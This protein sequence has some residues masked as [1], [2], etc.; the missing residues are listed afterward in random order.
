MARYFSGAFLFFAAA[1]SSLADGAVESDAISLPED[2]RVALERNAQAVSTA[3]TIESVSERTY[4]QTPGTPAPTRIAQEEVQKYFN[5]GRVYHRGLTSLKRRDGTISTR[6][7]EISYDGHVFYVGTPLEGRHSTLMKLLGENPDGRGVHDPLLKDTYL[8]AAGFY[9]PPTPHAWLS[10]TLNSL[11]IQSVN[12]G[13][14]LTCDVSENS[15]VLQVEVPDRVVLRAGQ[16]DIE[17][18]KKEWTA[19]GTDP[20]FIERELSIL[21]ELKEMI[22][23]RVLRFVLDPTK[24][25]AVV[26]RSETTADGKVILRVSCSDFQSAGEATLQLPKECRIEYFTIPGTLSDHSES[27]HLTVKA[28]LKNVSFNPRN[29]VQFAL[30]Y[31]APGT[32]VGDRSTIEAKHSASG[33]VDFSVGASEEELARAAMLVKA[34]ESNSSLFVAVNLVVFIVLAFVWYVRHHRSA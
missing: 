14:L 33:Q 1:L 26:E 24:D 3:C 20:E 7:N 22:P 32:V 6:T 2:V 27:P 17:A 4:R 10:E 23:K 16:T 8:D 29:D 11:V 9:I 12:D 18:L 13:T 34:T 21:A 25:C 31:D 15:V 5:E 28:M 30:N 19:S